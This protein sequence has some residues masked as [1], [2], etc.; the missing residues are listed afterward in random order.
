MIYK[1]L[2]AQIITLHFD[3]EHD[4]PDKESCSHFIKETNININIVL[5]LLVVCVRMYD[6]IV[7][8]GGVR[9]WLVG[10]DDIMNINEKIPYYDFKYA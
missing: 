9:V 10:K 5:T 7:G 1:L 3:I 8:M 2:F 4:A 6:S